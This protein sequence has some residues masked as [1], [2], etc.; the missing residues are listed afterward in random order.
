[1]LK[2]YWPTLCKAFRDNYLAAAGVMVF[3]LISFASSAQIIQYPNPGTYGIG[4]HRGVNDST[5]YFPTGCG[6]PTDSTFLHSYGFTGF[7]Q[8]LKMAA[9]YYDSCG[10]HE[11]VWDPSL[12]TWHQVDGA[13]G[14]TYTADE[15]TL[16][17]NGSNQFS[18]LS[19]YPGQGSIGTVGTI[20]SGIW[21]ST[22]IADAF[23]A[24]SAAWNAKLTSV[25]NSAN[26]FVGNGSNIATAVT[27]SGD[28][29]INNTGVNALTAVIT[30][31]TCTNCNLTW[32]AKGRLLVAANGTG[33]GSGAPFNDNVALIQNTADNTRKLILNAGTVATGTTRTLTAPNVNGTIAT[34]DNAQTFSPTE[35]FT[36]API[37]TALT[38][39][40]KG[41]GSSAVT[42]SATVPTTDLSG[43]LQA[44][45]EPAHTGDV[46]NTAG[47]LA[48]IL[49]STAVTPGSYTN[50]N[51]TVDAKGRLTAAA[52]GSGSSITVVPQGP[53]QSFT[54]T[55]VDTLAVATEIGM[56]FNRSS[57]S[58]I[59]TDFPTNTGSFTTS[60]G[61]IVTGTGTALDTTKYISLPDVGYGNRWIK[62]YI[63]IAP[64]KTST[65]PSPQVGVRSLVSTFIASQLGWVDLSTGADAGKTFYQ[66]K[67][68][69]ATKSTMALS[70]L[71]GDSIL[72]YTK[73]YDDSLWVTAINIMAARRSIAT[74][75][76]TF[77]SSGS[78]SLENKGVT[79]IWTQGDPVSIVNVFALSHDLKYA[80][81]MW[82]MDSKGQLYNASSF[83]K[84]FTNQ[85]LDFYGTGV[86]YGQTG[87]K[88]Q[89]LIDEEPDIFIHHPKQFI[90]QVGCNDVGALSAY[91]TNV[92]L[93]YNWCKANGIRP[94]VMSVTWE[95]ARNLD[96][97]YVWQSDP[98]RPWVIDGNWIDVYNI[99]RASNMLAADGTHLLDH[100][101]DSIATRTIDQAVVSGGVNSLKRPLCG[102]CNAGDVPYTA[103]A[104]DMMLASPLSYNGVDSLI[105]QKN[106]TVTANR[107]VMAGTGTNHAPFFPAFY[108]GDQT[109]GPLQYVMV[110]QA[111][112]LK[113]LKFAGS[114]DIWDLNNS[115]GMALNIAGS[116]LCIGCSIQTAA[117][118]VSHS[119]SGARTAIL[120]QGQIDVGNSDF[121]GAG[122]GADGAIY[123]R[124]QN[125][126]AKENSLSANNNGLLFAANTAAMVLS[127]TLPN[128]GLN[129]ILSPTAH[130][131]IDAGS[132][133]DP[134]FKI[135]GGSLLTT[136]QNYAW[137]VTSTH[138]NWTDGSGVRHQLDQQTGG[139]PPFADN[140]AI[141]MN[142]SDN[143]KLAKLDLSGITT[144][145]T[146]TYG[147]PDFNGIFAMTNHAQTWTGAQDMT[148]ATVTVATKTARDSAANAAS[149]KYV[150][151]LVSYGGWTPTI[152]GIS[153]VSS[154]TLVMATF[155][156]I[157]PLVHCRIIVS[158]V[159]TSSA[160]VTQ[161]NMSIPSGLA[162]ASG[163]N[164]LGVAS[165]QG[166]SGVVTFTSGIVFGTTSVFSCEFTSLAGT[167]NKVY[168][169]F[170]Y[171]L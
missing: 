62:G 40:L 74:L 142:N 162:P 123:L 80:N 83:K 31:G 69:A 2:A 171:S 59:S 44:A 71:A 38:G 134:P 35:T 116:S 19:T 98:S 34:I 48:T 3:L 169:E 32:D 166:G 45:Q 103:A 143:T 138:V 22:P 20:T 4:Y 122:A 165:I 131:H 109:L 58:S 111:G 160:T 149:T 77:T 153:N 67:G 141:A 144:A 64:T 114:T 6:A 118:L 79:T 95:S 161:F 1:M 147:L 5:F 159:P 126:A 132:T 120:T 26:I 101:H 128:I 14:A 84:V 136:P 60:S 88:I 63:M 92:V 150:D 9:K 104:P 43:I 75:E 106:T 105:A 13:S 89:D 102:N 42:A 25:L 163:D 110:S 41:N 50:P 157:G 53:I 108:I 55:G 11:Y 49:A 51:I 137:E 12:R 133:T 151:G 56:T 139:S 167:N 86:N 8:K 121:G 113:F 81:T 65:S 130:F 76:Y 23:I 146:R 87:A 18:I 33:G 99:T 91:Q 10:H 90:I 168:M 100:A 124:N 107:Y 39:Y 158:V 30:A 154:S 117:G 47:S 16:H 85:L 129:A 112:I 37:F 115:G 145:T 17:L 93:F 7:G 170:D 125:T 68:V 57:F 140:T 78:A 27:P 70:W 24:S 28:W 135:D 52:S 46:T 156:K 29:T 94:I 72:V 21:Q 119:T 97:M 54:G 66:G 73:R 152:T 155:T 148:G 36:L 164:D 96:A 127:R 82:G 15:S 61:H